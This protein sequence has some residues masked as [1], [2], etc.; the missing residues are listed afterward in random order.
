MVVGSNVVV[1]QALTIEASSDMAVL[2]VITA[3][4]G[5][6]VNAVSSAS[7]FAVLKWVEEND[8]AESWTA[9][10]DTDEVWTAQSDTDETWTVQPD[11]DEA[12]TPV[13]ETS[14]AWH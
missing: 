6:D 1:N 2:A 11:T 13:A 3:N 7:V 14:V 12:W 9:Q 4:M 8:T 10:P 5:F